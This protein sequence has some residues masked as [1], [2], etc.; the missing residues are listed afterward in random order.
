[1]T[2]LFRDLP[3]P[4]FLPAAPVMADAAFIPPGRAHGMSLLPGFGGWL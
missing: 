2:A 3:F 4:V 1:M